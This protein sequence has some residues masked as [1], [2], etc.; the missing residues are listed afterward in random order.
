MNLKYY[1][2][3]MEATYI[4]L[5]CDNCVVHAEPFAGVTLHIIVG[6]LFK[7]RLFAKDF[8]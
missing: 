3:Q 7:K 1:I 2:E 5:L 4:Y 8:V 6:S